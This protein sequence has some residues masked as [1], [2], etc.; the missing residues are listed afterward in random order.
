MGLLLVY[1]RLVL[2]WVSAGIDST[3]YT[4]NA[5]VRAEKISETQTSFIATTVTQCPPANVRTTAL[6]S[7]RV[8]RELISTT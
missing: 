5:G 2:L 7:K 1:V 4:S 3:H 8:K 6:Q